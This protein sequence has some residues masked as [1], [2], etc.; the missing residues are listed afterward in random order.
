[1][2]SAAEIYNR[3]AFFARNRAEFV[4]LPR[5]EI[6]NYARRGDILPICN[7]TTIGNVNSRDGRITRSPKK[8]G[9]GLPV[10]LNIAYY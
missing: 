10:D 1:M 6:K 3:E 9:I 7:D 8:I 4:F 5:W 2:R